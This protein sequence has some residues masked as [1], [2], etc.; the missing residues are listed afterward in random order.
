MTTT[1]PRPAHPRPEH[2]RPQLV[3]ERWA[4]LNGEWEF[5]RDPGDTGWERGLVGVPLS[6]RILVPFAPES[7]LSGIGDTDFHEAVW[8]RRT[9]DA[10]GDWPTDER[11]LLHFQAVDHDATVWVNG[12]E[13]VRHRGGFTPFSADITD[14]LGPARSGVLTVRARDHRHGVQARGKQATWFENTHAFFERHGNK[15][16]VLGRF[17]PFVRTYVTVVAGIGQMERRR[18]YVWSAVG[19]V[20]WVLVITLLGYF[21]GA[22][23]P[24]LGENIDKIVIVLALFTVIPIAWEWWRH[25]RHAEA[26]APTDG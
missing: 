18:F 23:F 17:V 7:T 26:A 2:P 21:L 1:A 11:I 20:L 13:V 8:Y 10:P 6:A 3:R 12:V 24:S 25:H 9:I 16:L 15:A 14:A 22:A 4:S 19:A 5:E